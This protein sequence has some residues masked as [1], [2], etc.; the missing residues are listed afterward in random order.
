MRSAATARAAAVTVALARAE[1]SAAPTGTTKDASRTARCA[2]ASA[3]EVAS[4]WPSVLNAGT[5]SGVSTAFVA[6]LT[7]LAVS[8]TTLTAPVA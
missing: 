5:P 8:S 7:R 4:T 1:L 2:L 3:S 6:R